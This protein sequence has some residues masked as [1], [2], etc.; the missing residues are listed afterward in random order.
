MVDP[1]RTPAGDQ[2]LRLAVLHGGPSSEHDISV[3]T[4]RGVIAALRGGGHVVHSV[5]VDRDGRWHNSGTGGGAG[6]S[7]AEGLDIPEALA[8]L[9]GLYLDCAFLGFHGTYGEYG[10]IQAALDLTGVPYSASGVT[11]TAVA[12]DKPMARY[13]LAAHGLT[14]AKARHI[15][16]LELADR[17]HAERAAASIVADLGVPVVVKVPAGGSSV[18]IE[19]PQ[20]EAELIETLGRL[21]EGVQTLLCEQFVHGVELTASVLARRDGSLEALPAV[22]IAPVGDRFFDY[23]AKYDPSLTNEIVP[24]RIPPAI[25]ERVREIGLIAHNALGCRGVSRTDLIWDRGGE[26]GGEQLV[27]LETNTLPGLTPASLLPKA[28]L[29]VDCDYLELLHRIIGASLRQP[30]VPT[31]QNSSAGKHL[32]SRS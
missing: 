26:D 27:V 28:A 22:E 20:T 17:E 15:A 3:I 4:A 23:E 14:V 19:I 32:C 13:L 1:K 8:M 9:R 29:A 31:K 21:R 2:Q 12:M 16:T 18:G 30:V 24:A 6:V 11:A 5:Y 25:E 10:R 7:T